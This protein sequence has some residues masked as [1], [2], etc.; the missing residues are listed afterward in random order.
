MATMIAITTVMTSE[1]RCL[2]KPLRGPQGRWWLRHASGVFHYLAR[3][4]PGHRPFSEQVSLPAGRYTLGV[5]D[6]RLAVEV[7]AQGTSRLLT[8]G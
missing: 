1:G 3:T 4:H 7:S 2:P 6:L 5:G 8:A